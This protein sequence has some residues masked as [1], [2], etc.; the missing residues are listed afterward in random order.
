MP[1]NLVKS[2]AVNRLRQQE[3]AQSRRPF[4]TRGSRLQ[5]C[6]HCLL[7]E[8]LCICSETP[9]AC[10]QTAVCL[11][12]FKGE[13]FK[14]SNSGRLIAD[15]LADN[16]AYLWSRTEPDPALLAL[17]SNPNYAPVIV[18]PSQY[19]EAERS[20]SDQPAIDGFQQQAQQDGKTVLLVFLDG[21]WR[22]AR[23]MFRSQWL[24]QLPVLGIQPQQSSGYALRE[25]FHEHQ[26]GTAEVAIEVLRAL[27]DHSAADALQAYF[28]LFRQRYLEG[29]P[30]RD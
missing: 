24:S 14:P 5:R 7:A 28:R 20:L 21:T 1:D 9:D 3:K 23:K 15:V 22:E 27:H 6:D 11:L 17:L 2:T 13:V 10:G 12:Y 16:H 18:F 19:A 4:I 25:A 26:L 29:K 8:T 30:G